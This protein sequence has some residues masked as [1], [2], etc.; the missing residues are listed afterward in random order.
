MRK[1]IFQAPAMWQAVHKELYL[2]VSYFSKKKMHWIFWLSNSHF[3]CVWN[4]FFPFGVYVQWISV[5]MMDHLMPG[6]ANDN[7]RKA[8]WYKKWDNWAQL[9]QTRGMLH[10]SA[11]YPSGDS[12]VHLPCRWRMKHVLHQVSSVDDSP[13][14]LEDPPDS[15]TSGVV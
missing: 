5:L 11:V 9:N 15:L 14:G 8:K 7:N 12:T 1:N 6:T 13:P 4:L 10:C 2:K 3:S